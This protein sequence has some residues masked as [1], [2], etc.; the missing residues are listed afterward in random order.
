MNPSTHASVI[1]QLSKSHINRNELLDHRSLRSDV[2]AQTLGCQFARAGNGHWQHQLIRQAIADRCI[3]LVPGREFV[4]RHVSDLHR[5][6]ARP[7]YA[8]RR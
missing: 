4:Y 7:D 1:A 8:F 2:I 5:K 6:A 3:G